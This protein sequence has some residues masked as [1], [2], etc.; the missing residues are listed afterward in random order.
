MLKT[1]SSTIQTK[2]TISERD[3]KEFLVVPGVPAKEQ[4]MNTAFVP[5]DEISHFVGSWNGIPITIHHPK[6]NSGSANAPDPDVAVVGRFYNAGWDGDGKRLTG[7]YWLDVAELRRWGDGKAIEEAVRNGKM[8]ETSTG[9]WADDEA[10]PGQFLGT[11][12]NVVHRNLRPDHIAILPD[13]IG[14]CSLADGCG[15]NRNASDSCALKL[16]CAKDCPCKDKDGN[17]TMTD[18][19]RQNEMSLEQ[20]A[21][22]VREAFY[23]STRP[24]SEKTANVAETPAGRGFVR[25]VF[26]DYVIIDRGGQCFQVPYAKGVDGKIEFAQQD[27]WKK[28]SQEWVLQNATGD[29]P[30]A[31]K[32]IWESVY[33]EAQKAGDDKETAAKKAWGA[34]KKA[35]WSQDEKGKW[36]K[37]NAVARWLARVT[38]NHYGPGKHKNGTSQD[39]HGGSGTGSVADPIDRFVEVSPKNE[40][41][42]PEGQKKI[43]ET[44]KK[45]DESKARWDKNNLV[46]ETPGLQNASES[47]RKI[48]SDPKSQK[49]EMTRLKKKGE[50]WLGLTLDTTRKLGADYSNEL[51]AKFGKENVYKGIYPDKY[52]V[53]EKDLSAYEDML[54]QARMSKVRSHTANTAANADRVVK[55]NSKENSMKWNDL[56]AYLSGKG[57]QVKANSESEEEEPTFDVSEVA[58]AKDKEDDEPEPKQNSAILTDGELSALKALAQAAPALLAVQQN[59]AR[60]A[61]DEKAAVVAEIKANRSN[62]YSDDELA[63]MSLPVLTKLNAQMNVN[64]AGLGGARYQEP[65]FLAVPA[66]LLAKPEKEA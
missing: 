9:Y 2:F 20:E 8:L 54:I 28:A 10:A 11:P 5:G 4:V 6:Q 13:E 48:F 57:I 32:K 56:L 34:V 43:D 45:F 26:E 64:Y 42:S 41:V 16:N 33:Q 49:E 38:S 35:G 63:G 52:K 22:A 62:V 15:V 17:K 53:F 21:Q 37:A 23:T 65:D 47:L 18:E 59:A 46:S 40:Q 61:Q 3:G 50:N 31:G 60:Q 66:V 39:A 51:I 36:V 1:Q 27:Q 58:P 14:A 44:K 25:D 7:E 19:L 12:Y 30:A 24:A 29:L 55:T